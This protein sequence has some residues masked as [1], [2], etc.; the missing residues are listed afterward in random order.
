MFRDFIYG[1]FPFLPNLFSGWQLTNEQ[2]MV[3]ALFSAASSYIL[4]RITAGVRI[5][6]IP[7]SF[8]ACFFAA[9]FAN[10]FFKD[11]H[12][13]AV[14]ELQ[15]TL[16]FTVVGHMIATTGYA[17]LLQC[18]KIGRNAINPGFF[19]PMQAIR[20]RLTAMRCS[21]VI[22]PRARPDSRSPSIFPLRQAT[23]PTIRWH[24]VKAG[25]SVFP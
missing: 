23:T 6:T 3:I 18:N 25:A 13:M 9:M 16:M 14:S 21:T 5:L 20:R 12:M 19:A 11:F 15:K 10:W 2:M 7:L 24:A 4:V 17:C 8:C 1:T 22:L